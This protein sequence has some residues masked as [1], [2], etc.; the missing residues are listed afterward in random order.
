MYRMKTL[1]GDGVSSRREAQQET[2]AGVRCRALNVMTHQGMPR[3][4][5]VA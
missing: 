5:R 4:Q 1:F 2:G 3:S